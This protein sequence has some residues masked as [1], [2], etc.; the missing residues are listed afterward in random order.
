[1]TSLEMI[2]TK[3]LGKLELREP[4]EQSIWKPTPSTMVDTSVALK[5]LVDTLIPL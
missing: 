1:M 5:T 4:D 3:E 2:T